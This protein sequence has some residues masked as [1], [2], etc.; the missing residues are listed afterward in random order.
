MSTTMEDIR[1]QMLVEMQAE[2]GATYKPLAYVEDIEKN[3]F[4]TSNDRYGVRALAAS[5]QPGAT[6]YQTYNQIYEIIITKGYI[7]SAVGDSNQVQ[8][9]FDNRALV[10]DIYRRLVNGKVGLAGVVL[11]I[12]SLEID[13]PE[14]LDDDKVAIQRA[15]MTITY[16]LSLI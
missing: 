15:T 6:K 2:L 13:N 8:K 5:E 12:F 16:R 7:E 3:S 10:L 14:Y 11:N 9:A 1:D 4:R